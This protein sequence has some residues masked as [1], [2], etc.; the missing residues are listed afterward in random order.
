[1][2]ISDRVSK[3]TQSASLQVNQSQRKKNLT[4]HI[5]IDSIFFNKNVYKIYWQILSLL[6]V[7]EKLTVFLVTRKKDQ[8]SFQK[9]AI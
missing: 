3:L 2:G 4:L 6:W 7:A 8:E 9:D 1:M 5:G